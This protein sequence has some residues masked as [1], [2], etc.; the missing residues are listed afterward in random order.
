[1]NL[2]RAVNELARPRGIPGSGFPVYIMLLCVVPE[3]LLLVVMRRE[4]LLTRRRVRVLLMS[5]P[6]RTAS[7]QRPHASVVPANTHTR[8]RVGRNRGYGEIPLWR[9]ISL[10]IGMWMRIAVVLLVLLEDI[11]IW[12]MWSKT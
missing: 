6:A 1:M 7:S 9:G 11:R 2:V 4:V 12:I 10:R 5:K 8:T 3:L